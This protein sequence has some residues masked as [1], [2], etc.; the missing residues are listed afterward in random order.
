M[1]PAPYSYQYNAITLL[2]YSYW[3]HKHLENFEVVRG[4]AP[5]VVV[6]CDAPA[7]VRCDAPAV[8]VRGGAPVV[9]VRV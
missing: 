1:P 6:R 8:V 2:S 3:I 4:D 5:A 7:V 9:V